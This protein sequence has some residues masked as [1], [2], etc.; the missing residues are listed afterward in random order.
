VESARSAGGRSKGDLVRVAMAKLPARCP[1]MPCPLPLRHA[2]LALVTLGRGF[3][4]RLVLIAAFLLAQPAAGETDLQSELERATQLG[5]SA[6][7]QETRAA[8]DALRPRLDTASK[9]QRGEFLLLDARNRALAGESGEALELID[10]FLSSDPLPAQAMRAYSLGANI[11]MIA[12]RYERAFELLE[13]GLA[14]DP[15]L[16]DADGLLGLLSVA[17][18][19]H[20][21][22][23]QP[24]QA[25]EYGVRAIEYA[26]RSGD[27]RDRCVV[28]QRAAAAYKVAADA[29]QS[30]HHYRRAVALCA[31]AKD[32]VFEEVSR[33]GLA[34]LLRE[35]GRLDES[36]A[37][38][39][40]SIAGLARSGY[41][42]GQEEARFFR[43]RLWLARGRD[44][45]A[46]S[47]LLSL[48]DGLRQ[49]EHWDYLAESLETIAGIA[50]R[51][52][53]TAQAAQYWR[54][55]I[56]AREQHVDRDRALHLAALGVEFDLQ[57][58]EQ[59]LALLR[60]QSRVAEL[61]RKSQRQQTRLQILTAT[62]AALLALVLGLLLAQSRR[63]RSRLV[64]L[65]R[66]D[67][68][69]GLAN[70]SWFHESATIAC[71]AARRDGLPLTLVL[72]DIDHFKQVNDRHG[73]PAGDEVLRRVGRLL[74]ETFA[75]QG[76]I[77][78]IGGEE[79][80]VALPRTDQSEAVDRLNTFRRR[81]AESNPGPQGPEITMSFGVAERAADEP[82]DRLRLRADEALYEAK[83]AGRDR[84]VVAVHPPANSLG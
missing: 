20:G 9:E 25:L 14:L 82:F 39:E 33:Y 32:P 51:E 63:G 83:H 41:V 67:G 70:H 19:V 10:G 74:R 40:Q 43:A 13:Q 75:A 81:L 11:A 30:E 69:T 24:A 72:A 45:Q 27:L 62:A 16:A 58:K 34:D 55:A 26:E 52:G 2:A 31:D 50:M 37:L 6:P 42:I 12:R 1:L 49:R 38:F 21:Q 54:E 76:S 8:L 35:S 4:P 53:D 23:G 44:G 84:V 47:E 64:E 56:A 46:R 73:H 65:S 77:G 59:E 60:E 48:L 66:H 17:S 28:H 78:R 68:L 22:A 18:Y 36:E 15:G 57:L 3:L 7:W 71:E 79:F 80:A 5:I 29:R 61:E